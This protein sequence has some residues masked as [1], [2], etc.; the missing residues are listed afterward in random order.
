M[1]FYV[2]AI[3]KKCRYHYKKFSDDLLHWDGVKFPT[4]NRDINRFEENNSGKFS[5]N[6]V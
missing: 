3:L 6:R 2:N 5:F 4:G 1:I